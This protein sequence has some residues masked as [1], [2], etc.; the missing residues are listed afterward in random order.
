MSNFI[1]KRRKKRSKFQPDR[2]FVQNAMDEYLKNGGT[3]EQLVVKEEDLRI[4]NEIGG[5][6]CDTDHNVSAKIQNYVRV[7][8]FDPF[9][10]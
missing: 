8:G 7:K 5:T 9:K 3:I 10:Q 2:E 4:F 1:G 6:T